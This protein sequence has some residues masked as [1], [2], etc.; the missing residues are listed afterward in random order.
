MATAC[1]GDEDAQETDGQAP[2]LVALD[3]L[4]QVDRQQLE[5]EAQVQPVHEEIAHA[6]DV[7]LVGWVGLAVQHL[8][9][10]DFHTRLDDSQDGPSAMC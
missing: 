1:L 6:H 3:Q 5:H 7:V 2:E 4:V 9:D 10:A 8:Q